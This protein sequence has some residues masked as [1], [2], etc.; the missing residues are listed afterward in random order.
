MHV[1][2][3]NGCG[4]DFVIIQARDNCDYA[5]LAQTLCQAPEWQ[6][7]GLIVV[8]TEPLEM[9]FYNQDGS[10]APM[11][12]N[13]IRCFAKYV[14]DQDLSSANPLVVKT[15]AGLLT[16]TRQSA[17]PFYCEVAMGTPVYGNELIQGTDGESYI[18]RTV[19]LSSGPLEFTSLFMGTIH[20]VVF[21]EDAVAEL[22]LSRGEELC[23]HPLFRAQ[24]N[25]NFVQVL[26][27]QELLVRTYERGVGW[28][29]ACG[30]GCCAAY[31]VARDQG[32][33]KS[34]AV[35]VHLEQGELVISGAEEITMA[36]PAV[37]EQMVDYHN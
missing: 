32:K 10:Q 24:T 11:C 26:N 16:V 31:V 2:K 29:L 4:N 28:T 36:G 6:T 9:L 15:G 27:E 34:G 1:A 19:E 23:H 21:V 7:D 3:Y 22:E 5:Q 13:G 12:G 20:T 25:V 14:Y 8:D 37:F 35:T 30:T 18:K 17:E 33:V